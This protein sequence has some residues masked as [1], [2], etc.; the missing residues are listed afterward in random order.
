MKEMMTRPKTQR[1]KLIGVTAALLVAALLWFASADRRGRML[2]RASWSGNNTL[3]RCLVCLGTDPNKI[4]H[5]TGGALHGAAA[6]GNLNLMRFLIHH[7]A[8]VNAR[9]K[10]GITPL[11]EARHS[12]QAEAEQLLLANGA[13]PDTSSINAP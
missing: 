7:G 1:W 2:V 3:A 12:N 5:G 8:D 9:V 11:W 4:P 13:N 10:F 6:T